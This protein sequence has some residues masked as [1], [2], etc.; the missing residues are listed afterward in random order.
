MDELV[1]HLVQGVSG[2]GENMVADYAVKAILPSILSICLLTFFFYRTK[3][4]D[5]EKKT[6]TAALSG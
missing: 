4:N 6:I 1:F 3:K 2:A 5:H